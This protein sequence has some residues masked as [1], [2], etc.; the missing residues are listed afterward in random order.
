MTATT[1]CNETPQHKNAFNSSPQEQHMFAFIFLEGQKLAA[2]SSH[3]F[4][5]SF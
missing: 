1:S 2:M 5:T 4:G 3:L